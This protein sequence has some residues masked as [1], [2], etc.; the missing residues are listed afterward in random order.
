MDADGYE[1]ALV[2]LDHEGCGQEGRTREELE[3]LIE[4]ELSK[5]GWGGRAAAIVIV[6]EIEEW[7][8]SESPHVDEVLGWKN[9]SP[10][11][12]VWLQQKGLLAPGAAKACPPKRAVEAALREARRA[13]SSSI[14]EALARSVSV[15]RC[16]DPSFSKLR[17]VLRLWFGTGGG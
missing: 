14:F 13:R 17:D 7:C 9:R 10:N 1:H 16:T 4:G 6:P 3:G 15:E 2:V 11:L 8:W 12:R 5:A